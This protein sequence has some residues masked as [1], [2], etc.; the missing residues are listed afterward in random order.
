MKTLYTIC[1]FLFALTASAQQTL[2]E[3][4]LVPDQNPNYMISQTKYLALRDSLMLTMNTTVQ[5]TYKAFDWHEIKTQR[6]NTRFENR[7]QRRLNNSMWRNN[8]WDNNWNNG[9][10][11]RWGNNWNNGFNNNRWNFLQPNIGFNSGNWWFWF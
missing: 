2:S 7:M 8:D 4:T 11:N 5:Q 3:P 9:W 10:N 1:S 6:R